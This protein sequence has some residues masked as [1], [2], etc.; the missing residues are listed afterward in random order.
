MR[1]KF[2]NG[3]SLPQLVIGALMMA[4]L[5]LVGLRMVR[6]QMR[7]G[8]DFE[9]EF[10]TVQLVEEIRGL[11]ADRGHCKA[12]LQGKKATGVRL[13][14]L[15]KLS[16]K[17]F[18]EPVFELVA[19][20]GRYGKSRLGIERMELL[21]QPPHYIPES[22]GILLVLTLDKKDR[23][24]GEPDKRA[25]ALEIELGTS[26]EIVDC[27][28]PGGVVHDKHGAGPWLHGSLGQALKFEGQ[29]LELGQTQALSPMALQG[30]LR[31]FPEPLVCASENAGI[32][33]S[34]PNGVLMTCS[35]EGTARPLVASFLNSEVG[36]GFDISSVDVKPLEW[37]SPRSFRLCTISEA[38]GDGYDCEVVPTEG[39]DGPVQWM[40]RLTYKRGQRATC[41]LRCYE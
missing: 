10:E 19:A 31:L 5:L 14:S 1:G 37:K 36:V 21:A 18:S 23:W 22:G 29:R 27:Y 13:G 7:I 20:G 33:W 30:G 32:L 17:G 26:Q 28:A 35:R 25:I 4:G 12:T 11:L 16:P 40:A 39:S 3:F 34:S 38:A 24:S 9:E 6:D 2:N 8:R 41:R 15:N